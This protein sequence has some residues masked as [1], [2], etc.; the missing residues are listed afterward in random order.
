MKRARCICLL[1]AAVAFL[2]ICGAKPAPVSWTL[3]DYA[4][5]LKISSRPDRYAFELISS[6]PDEIAGS[7]IAYHSA[8]PLTFDQISNLSCDFCSGVRRNRRR[9]PPL[10]NRH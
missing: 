1:V 2:G 10:G 6:Q 5:V 8:Q 3:S 7:G 4:S 9:L